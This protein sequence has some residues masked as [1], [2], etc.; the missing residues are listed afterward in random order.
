MSSEFKG[1]TMNIIID[2]IIDQIDHIKEK[3][4]LDELVEK[5]KIILLRSAKEEVLNM[6]LQYLDSVDYDGN[7][8][9]LGRRTDKYLAKNFEKLKIFVYEINEDE[10]YTLENCGEIIGTIGADA[11]CFLYQKIISVDHDNLFEIMDSVGYEKYAISNQLEI[12]KFMG[13]DK[14]LEGRQIY[15]KLCEW[16]YKVG[17]REA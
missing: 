15:E 2:R 17:D 14:Y 3:S 7:L 1:L 12:V 11:I 9:I 10:K 8:Y 4:N 5:K 13:M 6:F 16:F